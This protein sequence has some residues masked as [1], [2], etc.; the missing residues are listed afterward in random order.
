MTIIFSSIFSSTDFF[1][2]EDL[3]LIGIT[4]AGSSLFNL[5]SISC[6]FD[7]LIIGKAP[8]SSLLIIGSG[9]ISLGLTLLEY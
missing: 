3:R 8:F 6:S 2:T 1:L 5:I 7:S 4:I 9:I